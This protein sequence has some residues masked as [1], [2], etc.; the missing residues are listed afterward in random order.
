MLP[1]SGRTLLRRFDL[2]RRN[3]ATYYAV[4]TT[5]PAAQV[6]KPGVE[7]D[8]VVQGSGAGPSVS[9]VVED[10]KFSIANEGLRNQALKDFL[11][12]YGAN[13]E[14]RLPPVHEVQEGGEQVPLIH[15]SINMQPPQAQPVQ[16][17]SATPVVPSEAGHQVFL[18][19]GYDTT[20]HPYV[21]AIAQQPNMGNA[22]AAL[23]TNPAIFQDAMEG[24]DIS[25]L[26]GVHESSKPLAG[27]AEYTYTRG[28]KAPPGTFGPITVTTTALMAIH[29][30]AYAVYEVAEPVY[31]V[32]DE[33]GT[34]MHCQKC[35][36]HKKQL[37]GVVQEVKDP[38]C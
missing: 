7:V 25:K 2:S 8:I 9:K 33:D 17:A 37:D 3:E 19:A 13:P 24:K 26:V 22:R 32:R 30:D 35:I 36:C 23:T 15:E 6:L 4:S 10:L 11:A 21:Q 20:P 1:A 28:T 14:A 18:P 31:S 12:K 16:V 38:G 27:S 5:S 29:S 34:V